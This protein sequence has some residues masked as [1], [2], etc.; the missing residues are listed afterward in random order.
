MCGS[1]STPAEFSGER[2]QIVSVDVAKR[3]EE[4]FELLDAVSYADFIAADA[5]RHPMILRL[6]TA[7]RLASTIALG[8]LLSLTAQYIRAAQSPPKHPLTGRQI[9]DVYTDAAWLDR[10][11]REQEEQPDRALELIGIKPGMIVAD[12]GAGSGFMTMRLARLVSPGGMVYAND[13]QP[14]M[15]QLLE[16]RASAQHVAN[17]EFVQGTDKDVRLPAA[18]IDLALLVD[19]YHEFWYPQ[20]M[21]RSIRGALRPNGQLVLLEYRKEDP[22][23]PIHPDHKMSVSEVRTELEAEGLVFDRLLDGLPM[24]HILIFRSP[25]R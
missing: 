10:P 6:R 22:K 14:S 12:V 20:E 25:S 2:D 9:A 24:Q 21:L 7:R 13:L 15:L 5:G 19:V 17:V 8:L 23:L 18:A 16:Q 3:S 1:P 11:T 4:P